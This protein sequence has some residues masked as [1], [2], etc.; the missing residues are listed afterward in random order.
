MDIN[1][2]LFPCLFCKRWSSSRLHCLTQH[3]RFSSPHRAAL[4]GQLPALTE[5]GGS[6]QAHG[7]SASH[8][9]F[10]FKKSLLSPAMKV[11]TVAGATSVFPP[12]W[13]SPTARRIS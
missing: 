4:S 11:S 13:S 2:I 3:S 1:G 10:V 6:R 5:L 12:I 7:K 9:E 8:S